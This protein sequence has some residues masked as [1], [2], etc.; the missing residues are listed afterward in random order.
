MTSQDILPEIPNL[1]ISTLI[2][3]L[4]II[5]IMFTILINLPKKLITFQ[6]SK[7]ISNESKF[8][9]NSIPNSQLNHEHTFII[10]TQPNRSNLKMSLYDSIHHS[11][12][13][14]VSVILVVHDSSDQS[15]KA[16]LPFTQT[17]NH[18]FNYPYLKEFIIWN[19]DLNTHLQVQDYQFLYEDPV[20]HHPIIRIFNPPGNLSLSMT[21]HLSCSLSTYE[22]CYFNDE[23]TVYPFLD[24]LYTKYIETNS[25]NQSPITATI[26]SIN[27]ESDPRDLGGSITHSVLF[28]KFLSTRY[29]RQLSYLSETTEAHSNA[30]SFSIW[31]NRPINRLLI[32]SPI[33]NFSIPSTPSLTLASNVL[34][35]MM[36][37]Y[38]P[39]ISPDPFPLPIPISSKEIELKDEVGKV[40]S[41]D[42]RVLLMN[43]ELMEN[44]MIKAIDSDLKTCWNLNR[45]ENRTKWVGLN[46]IKPILNLNSLE[47]NLSFTFH[48]SKLKYKLE[49]LQSNSINWKS[50]NGSEL[51]DHQMIY[52]ATQ[53][54]LKDVKKIK[55]SFEKDEEGV[56]EERIEICG[57]I[58]NED[59]IL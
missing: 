57:W 32:P 9:S 33:S 31:V 8:K 58:I 17:L 30:E 52:K 28:P 22:T 34:E 56:E 14:L 41:L 15:K 39:M 7:S 44:E 1:T 29:L 10:Q 13:N 47:I 2:K 5:L 36:K 40:S 37:M 55:L 18:L 49:Y 53:T 16:L 23:D 6:R 24:S 38:D 26:N 48:P 19:N 43:S 21:Q 20:D 46:F 59:W 51:N 45:L 35:K 4:M 3:Q 12:S 54:G 11:N 27:S 50:M 42:D 25:R